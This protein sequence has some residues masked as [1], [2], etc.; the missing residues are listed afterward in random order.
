MSYYTPPAEA[1]IGDFSYQPESDDDDVD[2]QETAA[3]LPSGASDTVPLAQQY[4]DK[5]PDTS[6]AASGPAASDP[7]Q[8]KEAPAKST[9]NQAPVEGFQLV[10]A[11]GLTD[12]STPA[13]KGSDIPSFATPTPKIEGALP[14]TAPQKQIDTAA[15]PTPLAPASSVGN[16]LNDESKSKQFNA[17]TDYMISEFFSRQV[18]RLTKGAP[19]ALDRSYRVFQQ[20]F[21]E[22]LGAQWAHIT[23]QPEVEEAIKHVQDMYDYFESLEKLVKRQKTSLEKVNDV[24]TELSLWYKKEGVSES[25]GP[26][27]ENML[28]LSQSYGNVCSERT[29]L[30]QAYTQ[31]AEFLETF[32]KKAIADALETMKKQHTSRLELDSYGSKLGQLEEKKLKTF[33]KSPSPSEQAVLEKELTGCRAKFQDAK[34]KYQAHSTALIDKAG[35]LDLKKGVDFQAHIQKIREVHDSFNRGRIGEVVIDEKDVELN[36]PYVAE[37]GVPQPTA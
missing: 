22:R 4:P 27:R 5:Q 34:S 6:A 21:K 7:K 26:I 30:I 17:R 35:L 15:F 2:Q 12:T 13:P 23:S 11:T 36:D 10:Q 20:R 25:Q 1:D 29:L 16:P 28:Y 3:S 18:A 24:E 33:A 32:R 19:E 9:S 14:H 37:H 31:Y 8:T